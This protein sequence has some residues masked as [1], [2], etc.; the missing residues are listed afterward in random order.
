MS[1][2][3]G[4][5]R[6]S[7]GAAYALP[8]TIILGVVAIALAFVL[9][10]RGQVLA[11]V[12]P[13]MSQVGEVGEAQ[14]NVVAPGQG[15]QG[16]VINE[17][18]SSNENVLADE[19]G[20]YRDFIEL[21]N[22]SGA[23]VDISGWMINDKNDLD[24]TGVFVFPQR[25]MQPGEYLIVFASGQRTGGSTVYHAPF[26]ISSAGET[27]YLRDSDGAVLE[28]VEVPSMSAN[29]SYARMADGEWSVTGE[30]TPYLE[31]TTENHKLILDAVPTGDTPLVINEAMSS[32]ASYAVGFGGNRGYHDYI[33][34]KN[35]GVSAINLDGYALSDNPANPTKWMF[36]AVTIQPGEI[37]IV[38]AS[39]IDS[40]DPSDLHANFKLSSD[41]ETVLLYDNSGRL[42]IRLEVPVLE[43]DMSLSLIEDG[44]YVTELLPTPG[45][46]NDDAGARQVDANLLSENMH[47]IYISEVMASTA[48]EN[49]DSLS[50]DWIE[51]YNS[52]GQAID[53]SG[54]GLSD[55][56]SRPRK[57]QIPDGVTI[58]AGQYLVIYA[59]GSGKVKLDE[60]KIN[61]TYKISA[62]G[63]ETV[64]LSTPDGAIVDKIPLPEQYGEISYG[65]IN[66]NS[67]LTYF[68][69]PTLGSA[70]YGTGVSGKVDKV[71]FSRVGGIV[72]EQSITVEMYAPEGSTVYYTTDCTEPSP[73]SQVYSGPITLSSTTVIRA[74]AYR[75]GM[76]PSYS[77]AVTYLFEQGHTLPVV[78]V[79]T[80]PD[81]LWSD[82]K[83]I[84]VKGPNAKE[85]YPYG[86]INNGANFWYR[87]ERAGHVE[88]YGLNGEQILSQGMGLALHGQYSRAEEQKAFSL[89]ARNV[90]GDNLFRAELFPNRDYTEYDSFLLRSSGNDV[91][92]SRMADS[93]LTTFAEDTSV[94]Y[95]D[96]Q[97]VAVYLNGEYWGHYN[98]R[99]RINPYSIAQWEGW[100]DPENIDLVKANK[101]TRHGS[102]ESFVELTDWLKQ[103]GCKTPENL[104]YVAERVDIDNYLDY[105][106]IQMYVAN[107]DLLNAR[108]YR[109]AVSGDGKWRWVLFDLDWA[110]WNSQLDLNSVRRWLNPGGAGRENLYDNTLFVKLMENK[111][112]EEKFFLRLGE[113]MRTTFDS[114]YVIAKF[115]ARYQELLPEMERHIQRYPNVNK[116]I[117]DWTKRVNNLRKYAAQRPE[118]M[119]KY[120]QETMKF[121]EE[122]M[123]YY[124]GETMDKVGYTGR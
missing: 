39:G 79:V 25:V 8:L 45:Y 103:N 106:A 115:D 82:E 62:K 69:Q 121:S 99:E 124:F 1:N 58:G 93:V 90:Y 65:R 113:L 7:R 54:W 87:W 11:D 111:E 101:D 116:S 102:N 119:L 117:S 24:D 37:L 27:V 29:Q 77:N 75:D 55:N 120:I 104:A 43:E 23:P 22:S 64:V 34:F 84:Y 85:K 81:N 35:T 86:S 36:P 33:E 95:Q 83:G 70:N 59:S 94:M 88:Y 51:L 26:K 5:S 15:A 108:R 110:F 112:I 20:A 3:S 19:Q 68:D 6:G 31:N 122:T 49:I 98:M 13:A 12:A 114:D 53:L 100:D 2:N 28:S 21:Y 60:N 56:P 57:W 89:K 76:L 10:Y 40:K 50:N 118:Y 61:T 66:G 44:S 30:Y 96:S 71:T 67:T 92:Y 72:A 109:N 48:Q 74:M 105:V 16:V 14:A 32:N 78:C 38:M 73:Q 4:D 18:M 91:K 97:P 52:S 123:R 46:E 42:L 63:W 17:I 80:E 41:G 9:Q 107:Q 47:G